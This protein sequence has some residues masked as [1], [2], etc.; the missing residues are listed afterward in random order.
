M[1]EVAA[2]LGDTEREIPLA[3]A[4]GAKID[5]LVEIDPPPPHSVRA[6]EALVAACGK[7]WKERKPATGRYNCAGHVWASRR[8]TILDVKM[9]VLIIRDDG[10][11]RLGDA[12][13][14]FPGDIAVYAD[15]EEGGEILH[16]GRVYRLLP[17]LTPESPLI[18]Y[19]ISKWNS[20][21]GESLHAV[22]DVPYQK[23]FPGLL[24]YF[25]TDRP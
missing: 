10:Y 11:R 12:E 4:R 16:V 13:Q 14:V 7:G 19:V 22:F 20:T 15:G 18:P 2:A 1:F 21:S 8:T 17:G 9:Y 5:N 6:Y 24:I 25:L 23:H 3:T